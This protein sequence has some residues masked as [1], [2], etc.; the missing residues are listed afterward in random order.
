M[1]YAAAISYM[2]DIVPGF[3]VYMGLYTCGPII[4]INDDAVSDLH[5]LVAIV[6]YRYWIVCLCANYIIIIQLVPAW[7][8]YI[9]YI[10]AGILWDLFTIY[11]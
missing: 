5:A 4:K 3:S 10:S 1:L 6:T 8:D 11:T 7:V 2:H 9:V